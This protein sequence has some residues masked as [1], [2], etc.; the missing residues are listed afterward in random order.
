M[1]ARAKPILLSSHVWAS[2]EL[3]TCHEQQQHTNTLRCS[4]MPGTQLPT[5]N[6]GKADNAALARLVHHGDV[7]IKH[8]SSDYIDAVGEEYFCYCSKKNFSHNFCDFA[9]AFHL[10]AKY[11][12]ARRRGGKSMRFSLL[13]YSGLLK[14]PPSPL[15]DKKWRQR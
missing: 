5:K 9:A 2:Q 11:S 3:C 8:L 14:T 1:H 6:W 4:A 15:V 13:Y 12:R 10:E 7:D